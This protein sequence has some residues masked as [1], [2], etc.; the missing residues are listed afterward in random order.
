MRLFIAI[1]L[2]DEVKDN[3]LLLQDA[4]DKKD[5][6]FVKRDNLEMTIAFL[7][8]ID[9]KKVP[10]IM[11]KLEKIRFNAFNLKTKNIG[12]FPSIKKVRV[13]WIGL[14]ENEEFYRLQHEIRTVFNFKEKLMPHITIA[15]A[16][17]LIMDK[18]NNWKKKLSEVT[19]DE[20]GF[21]VDRFILYE[22]IPG[23]NGYEHKELIVFNS[24]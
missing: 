1:P 2:P 11:K 19:H 10:D 22:S 7:G 4:L 6:R 20:V 23:S 12:F 17:E 18:E 8:E 16:R 9:E 5:F 24:N 13:V 14:E 21:L 3:A 15:R